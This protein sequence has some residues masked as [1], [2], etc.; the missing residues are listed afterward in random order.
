[1]TITYKLF[2]KIGTSIDGSVNQ[3]RD[4]AFQKAIPFDSENGDYQ[5]YLEWVAEG[6]T[7]EASD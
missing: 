3:Y 7:A 5:R 6:N 4:G 1:M 2:K